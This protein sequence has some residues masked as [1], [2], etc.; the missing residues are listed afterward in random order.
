MIP[1]KRYNPLL[2]L[3]QLLNLIKNSIF[4]VVFLFVI[5][6]GSES[7]FIKY[8]KVIFILAFVITFISI[9]IKWFTTKYAF[10][11]K[12]FYL[13]KGVFS[14]SERSIPFSKIQNINRHTALFHRIF[15]V[16]S[17]SF[18]TGIKGEDAAVKFDV[19]SRIEAD[20]ME[21]QLSNT[22][23]VEIS[24][25]K[26]SDANKEMLS[27]EEDDSKVSSN[28]V[29]HFKPTTKDTL[30]A[31]FTSFS[32][33]LLIPLIASLYFKI[34]DIFHVEEE[35][36]GVIS[37][38]LSSWWIVF[39]IILV[40][41]IASAAFGVVS[42]FLKYGKYEISS[43]FD[44]I[45]ITKGVINE[46][47][48]SISKEKV[49]ALEIKQTIL[50]RLFGLAEVKLT[51]AGSLGS[52]EDNHEIN[53]LYPY[54]PI[55]RAYEIISEILPTYEV[56]QKMVR[57]PNK[58]LWVRLLWPSWIWI[59]TTAV[60]YYFK[61]VVLN[62]EQAW[63]I[64][65]AILLVVIGIAR[66]L[67]FYNTQYVLNDCFVQFKTG[68]LT[69]TLF[70]SKREKVI[71]VKVSRNIIQKLLG[72]ASIK[73]INRAKPVYHAG[74]EDVPQ[75]VTNVFCKWYRGRSG[76]IKVE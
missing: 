6:A 46:S 69:T 53:S 45:Y 2:M 24:A 27:C 22:V 61:P 5:K 11:N 15:R 44:R 33:L 17:I 7:A 38:I 64:I 34:N 3:F 71:E 66:L 75:E 58:S 32:F 42:T 30:K 16:T 9:I 8:G 54:L 72:L 13:Y 26:E 28:R 18:E 19:L 50:K 39:V 76:E 21:A 10:D 74:V 20:R 65:S 14:K 25:I 36:K 70:I 4:F 56:T 47:S 55:K 62:M 49:Q 40:L 60:L 35:A 57:L 63:W 37:G 68:S 29:M 48:F 73:T 43:D 41:V 1:A 31:S 59:L 51:S 67:D 12:S 52:G 23:H